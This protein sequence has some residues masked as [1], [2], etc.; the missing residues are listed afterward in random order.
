MMTPI[1]TSAQESD[2]MLLIV[3]QTM[4]RN[5]RKQRMTLMMRR[6]RT[7]R[8]PRTSRV[9]VKLKPPC[10]SKC[11]HHS[12]V[13]AYTVNKRSK[14]F[15]LQPSSAKKNLHRL[16][17]NRINTSTTK[18]ATK[19][20]FTMRIHSWVSIRGLAK[21]LRM[22]MSVSKP[23]KMAFAAMMRP[24]S[25]W[26]VWLSTSRSSRDLASSLRSFSVPS[27]RCRRRVCKW[28]RSPKS[29]ETVWAKY[30]C[31]LMSLTRRVI[32]CLILCL[33]WCRSLSFSCVASLRKERSV[34]RSMANPDLALQGETKLLMLRS[35]STAWSL[36]RRPE[37]PP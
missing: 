23:M 12:S 25:R 15:H 33:H 7:M 8:K 4:R 30:D 2:P 9:Y 22:P 3:E 32:C 14:M 21:A 17:I 16:A 11:V 20:W 19:D 1:S 36:P 24:Q 6:M 31:P 10:S 18:T 34:G 35:R 5:S 27:V 28:P 37:A 29:P 26:N 13:T